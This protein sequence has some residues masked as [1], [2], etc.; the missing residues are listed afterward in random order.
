MKIKV[1]L[2]K[3]FAILLM[4]FVTI[5]T[6]LALFLPYLI[7]V[8]SYR[9]EIIETLHKN[10][11]RQ[12][13][14]RT[15]SF[16][17]HFGPSFVFK[18]FEVKEP[19]GKT[20]LLSAKQVTIQLSLM[21]LLE[22]KVELK[23]IGLV[24]ASLSLIRNVDGKLN[25]DD[26]LEPGKES[27]KIHLKHINLK[28]CSVTWSDFAKSK[29]GQP[30]KLNNVQL[31][32]E[33]LARGQKG[34]IKLSA[35]I[36]ALSGDPSHLSFSGTV[37][38]PDQNISLLE[39]ELNCEVD[40]KQAEIGRY[41]AYYGKHIPFGNIGGRLDLSS[42]FKG[43]LQDFSAKGKIRISSPKVY[44]P[45]VFH[46]TLT[47]GSLQIDYTIKLDERLINL[48]SLTIGVDKIFGIKGNVQLMDYRSKDP[49][50]IANASTP[51]TFKYE[52]IRNYVPYGIIEKDASDYVENKI[53]SG[54][55]KLDTGILDGRISQIAH[56]EIGENYNTLT[57]RGPV[58]NAV[59]S[60]GPKAPTFN[61]IKGTIELKGKNFNLIGMS[62]LFGTSPFKLDGSITEYNTDKPSNYPVKMDIIPRS[63]EVAWLAGLAGASK[64]EYKNRSNLT[65]TGSGHHTAYNL[66][67]EWDLK[68]SAY[69]FPDTVEKVA[70]LP[71]NL[72]FSTV[73]GKTETKLTS[74]TYGLS[75]IIVS[76]NAIFRYE[77]I[78]YL[79]FNLQTNRFQLTDTAPAITIGKKYRPRGKVQANISGSGNPED[80]TAMN[81][82]GTIALNAFSVQPGDKLK[83]L[84]GINGAVNFQ[85]NGLETSSISARYG[86]SL[87]TI[88][89][90]I[91]KLGNPE[92]ELLITSPELFLSDMN[93]PVSKTD[94]SIKRLNASFSIRNGLYAI[95]SVSG[96]LNTS[97]FNI[98]GTFL[99]GQNKEA[100]LT[101]AS[102][103]LDIDDLLLLLPGTPQTA[104]AGSKADLK[105]RLLVD[106]GNYNK[107]QFSKLNLTAY[108]ESGTIYVQDLNAAVFG[109]KVT[110]KGRIAEAGTS[111]NRYNM[112]I[113]LDKVNADKLLSSL[114]ISREITGN[115]TMHADLTARGH[116][117]QELKK[118]ALGNIRLKIHSGKLR[119][120]STLSK[121]FSILNISQLL[122]FQL[123]DMVSGGMPYNSISGKIAV[124]DGRL[125]TQDLFISSDAINISII[126][127]S[128]IVKEEMDLTLGVQPL[129]TV[130]KVVNRIPIVGWLLTGKDKGFLTAYFEA[131][132]S[133][134]DPK[135]SAIP[136]KSMGMGVLNIFRRTFEL[137]VRLFTDTGEV[138]LGQ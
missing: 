24:E 125:S 120:F 88:K 128:D 22:K 129:Q 72:A 34:H 109:G 3:F 113:D 27:A 39:S 46:S 95:K 127:S 11:H 8:N 26:L 118:T 58:E 69:S 35:D 57:I 104:S 90:S 1:R 73:I 61:H 116:N 80:F 87:L 97:N 105:L 102:S 54:I 47:P 98:S 76:G 53:K 81:Y 117:L 126:G 16:A 106:E 30:V 52:E 96:Q 20:N 93:L 136:V 62:G 15:G 103:K 29:N 36:P 19:D 82:N 99:T 33:H 18:D 64:L 108:R 138:I 4:S 37:R 89:G 71:N 83:L 124:E 85:G 43:K 51:H 115:L 132:G 5:I 7:D 28:K 50:I 133:W 55:F 101:V 40:L 65:L 131:K 77:N 17:W 137:P 75:P 78:P 135:V 130:D 94:S 79:G 110:G 31:A 14:F 59:L 60:Y 68:D 100:D 66:T 107:M 56:M 70:G 6:S 38:L 21:P 122:K 9:T 13:N 42:S 25:I 2:F 86:N 48:S 67:G 45:T 32:M 84:S 121:V 91:A 112:S 134:A 44:W 114:D 74:L 63:P 41:W 12:V 49:R 111:G 10:L 123:P 119:K 23:N 92:A